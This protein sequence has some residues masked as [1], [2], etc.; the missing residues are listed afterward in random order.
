MYNKKYIFGL[1]TDPPELQ[2]ASEF[3]DKKLLISF[4]M[5]MR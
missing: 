3:P 2:K 4:A 1:C 5:L